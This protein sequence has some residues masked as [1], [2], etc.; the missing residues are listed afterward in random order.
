VINQTFLLS[1]SWVFDIYK[2]L[3]V[4]FLELD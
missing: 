4:T 2:H 3:Y 1:L